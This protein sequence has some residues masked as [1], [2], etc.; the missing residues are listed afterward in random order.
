MIGYRSQKTF[1]EIVDSVTFHEKD[2]KH[3]SSKIQSV[4]GIASC[5]ANELSPQ[6]AR[7]TRGKRDAQKDGKKYNNGRASTCRMALSSRTPL[8]DKGFSPVFIP[9]VTATELS[10][11]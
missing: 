10:P 8:V 6:P 9:Q 4:Y 11:Q 5:V 3:I 7:K 2:F 1:Y